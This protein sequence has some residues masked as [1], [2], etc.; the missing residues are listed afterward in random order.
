MKYLYILVI[1]LA[2]FLRVYGLL[3]FPPSLYWEEA[4]LGYDA[5]SILKTGKDHHGTV[6]PIVAFE[7]FGDWK[8]SGYFYIL[9]PFIAA[10][11]LTEWAVRLPT[12]LAGIGLLVG[13]ALL[14]KRVGISPLLVL[15]VGAIS[16]WAIQF[17]RAGWEVMSASALL[18]WANY[19]FLVTLEKPKIKVK[20]GI[21]GVLFFAA[22]MYTYH[23]TRLIVPLQLL[24]LAIY[25]FSIHLR[26]TKITITSLL[27]QIV[28]LLNQ[29]ITQLLV[30]L[31]I[32]IA[33]I[34]PILLSIGDTKTNHRFQ[35]T[36]IFSDLRVIEESNYLK[37]NAGNT[38]LSR[39]LYHRYILFGREIATNFLSH[40]NINFLFIHGDANLR[41][42]IQYFGQLY[43]IEA[44]FVL[45][46]LYIWLQ[47]RTKLHLY[48]LAWLFIAI[49]PASLTT[50]TPHALRILPSLPIFMLLIAQGIAHFHKV[51]SNLIQN[52]LP[53][54]PVVSSKFVALCILLI[55]IT[56]FT[57]FWRYYTSIYPKVA[58]SEWQYGY[59][60][61][62]TEVQRLQTE[63]P[64][65][66][67]YI[68]REQ[69]RP[70]MYYWFF[71]KTNPREVQAENSIVEKDQGEYLAYKNISFIDKPDQIKGPAIVV[72]SEK[73]KNQVVSV[74]S[75]VT[76]TQIRDLSNTVVWDIYNVN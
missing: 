21:A 58:S 73:F 4:A 57:G 7:S 60:Q 29:N 9:V 61:M 23:A 53:I 15:A 74:R 6:L 36:S 40:F 33:V 63:N 72:S 70:A 16:P 38:L 26:F 11:G 12:V 34:G 71:S 51:L 18:V 39:I 25:Y 3:Q 22:A 75:S 67:V 76:T 66:P 28:K 32:F 31:L 20:M 8:P 54:K 48:F 45:M 27:N 56:E 30:P 14:A 37:E 55:Y 5:Y 2:I 50:A 41:H 19:F 52:L 42:S 44:L 49:I 43:H 46:G 64:T 59:K 62:V 1:T 13:T 10:F 35:E 24:G 68:T 69:G 17:S 65:L 47:K